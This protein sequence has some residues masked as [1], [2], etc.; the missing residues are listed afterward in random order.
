MFGKKVFKGEWVAITPI[1]HGGDEKTGSEQLLKRLDFFSR[2]QGRRI[3]IPVISGNAVR[4]MLRRHCMA[5]FLELLDYKTRTLLLHDALFSGGNLQDVGK[6]LSDEE[7]KKIKRGMIDLK[8]KKTINDLI[9]MIAL[10]GTAYINQIFHGHL[11]SGI[12]YP[13]AREIVDFLPEKYARNKEILP[14]VYEYIS[15]DFFTRK[16]ELSGMRGRDQAAQQMLVNFEIFVPGSV[17]SHHFAIEDPNELLLSAFARAIKLW[18]EKPYIAAR[19]RS[20]LGEIKFTYDGLDGITDDIY[21]EHV[22]TNKDAI[23][24]LLEG[25]ELGMTLDELKLTVEVDKEDA[26][27]EEEKEE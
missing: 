17:F 7:K 10:F 3:E 25:L 15:R 20:G 23:I 5:D 14:S 26:E 4:G 2:E 6:V 24:S 13:V 16:D 27:N 18:Q 9:P 1:H 21:L 8:L 12:A 11:I 19:S 22:E